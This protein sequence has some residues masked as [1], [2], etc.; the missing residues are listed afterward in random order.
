MEVKNLQNERV[1]LKKAIEEE[2][3]EGQKSIDDLNDITTSGLV[4][5]KGLTITD[6]N[7]GLGV[8]GWVD[9]F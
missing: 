1:S 2:T 7:A 8:V 9:D 5:N 4:L 6:R 3:R